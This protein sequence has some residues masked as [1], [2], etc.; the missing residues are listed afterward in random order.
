MTL[1]IRP[2][3]LAI[4]T[5]KSIFAR[6]VVKIQRPKAEI[7][8]IMGHPAAEGCKASGEWDVPQKKEN[9]G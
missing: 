5:E 3:I 2:L 9:G 7:K 1:S 4:F 8:L 6:V